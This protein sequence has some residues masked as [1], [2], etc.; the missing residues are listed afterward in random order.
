MGRGSRRAEASILLKS[1]DGAWSKVGSEEARGIVPEGISM[2][3]NE[4]GPDTASFTLRRRSATPWPDLLA[5]NQC[6]IS[7]GGVPVWGGRISEAPISERRGDNSISVQARGWQYHL[8]DDLVRRFYVATDLTGY[9]DQR[10]FPTANLAV[11]HTGSRVEVGS[12]VIVLSQPAGF[13]VATGD[14]VCATFDAGDSL[15]KRVVVSWERIAGASADDTIYSN[16]NDDEDAT[17]VGDQSSSTLASASGTIAHTFAS[18]R[19]YHH[20]FLYR[21]G[22]G[23]TYGADQGVRITAIKLFGATAYESGNASILK[24]D[25]VL[26]DVLAS[27]AVPLLDTSTRDIAAGTFSIPD[28]NL[29]GYQTPRALIAAAN[30]YEGNL[31]GVDIN[32]RLFSRERATAPEVEVGHWSGSEF[33]DAATNSGEALYNQVIVQGTGPDGAPIEVLRT[34][35]SSLLTR[36]GFNRT[37]TLQVGAMLTTASAE[38]LGDI[39]LGEMSR[40]KFKGR[41]TV[42]GHGAARRV[43]GGG[44]HPSELLL[45]CGQQIRINHLIDPADGSKGRDGGLKSVSYVHDSE[46]STCELDN[47]R[48]NFA[49]FLETLDVLTKAA[50]R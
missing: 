35:T 38:A 40:P 43:I 22:A 6:E 14:Y 32:R 24:A 47:E 2:S 26:S 28:L 21:N 34:A 10:S 46:T 16:G 19:R 42:Q 12:G 30:A 29:T 25:Q 49:T 18:L 33:E 7:I 44:I 17:T 27:G 31:V 13:T 20:V 9:R 41:L 1:V 4:G 50:V 39:W 5:F 48:G 11:N 37:A 45:R 8:D 23:G 3:A 15:I 36:Q